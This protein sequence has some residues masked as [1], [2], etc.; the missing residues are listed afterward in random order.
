MNFQEL[1]YFSLIVIVLGSCESCDEDV[2]SQ[3]KVNGPTPY[4]RCL[5]KEPPK[6]KTVKL[7]RLRIEISERSL[8]IQGFK[9][10]I[11]IVA[12]SG[13]AYM[14][15]SIDKKL[16][17]VEK[18][19]PDLGLIVGGL[20]D[21]KM[22]A[23]Q[24][25]HSLSIMKFPILVLAGGR[26]TW[27]SFHSAFRELKGKATDRVIDITSLYSIRIGNDVLVPVAG[28]E[29]GRY[30]ISDKACGFSKHDLDAIAKVLGDNRSNR[31]WLV[32]WQVPS[33]KHYRAVGRAQN[34]MD[35]GSR[36]LAM[37][38]ERIGATGGIFAWPYIQ[39]MRPFSSSQGMVVP[40]GK[41]STDLQIV[42]P[43]IVGPV[44]ERDDGFRVLPGFAI[45]YLTDT[46]L[47]VES[48]NPN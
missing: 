34:G 1:F 12:F 26:D 33:S 46:G 40:F 10:P 11:R 31:R 44:M 36:E 14:R 16:R 15:T 22:T 19:Q 23:I 2:P 30:A 41:E 4:V 21:D 25:L 8:I 7:G 27:S 45:L 17:Q 9:L 20:G 29:N 32:S 39:V 37:L 48:Y 13:P 3:I 18:V 24:T 6:S 5:A 38:S 28:A 35:I 43:R 47:R 42:I